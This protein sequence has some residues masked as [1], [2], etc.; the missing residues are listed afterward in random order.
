MAKEK[1]AGGKGGGRH[2]PESA[3]P[4]SA[5]PNEEGRRREGGGPKDSDPTP[6][7]G[8]HETGRGSR[9]GGGL[10]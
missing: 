6:K 2:A 3:G 8:K 5:T 7:A 9:E 1:E 4:P 10:H